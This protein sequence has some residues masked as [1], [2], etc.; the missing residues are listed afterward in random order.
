MRLPLRLQ[1]GAYRRLSSVSAK[2]HSSGELS[3]LLASITQDSLPALHTLVLVAQQGA[4]CRAAFGALRHAGLQRLVLH[5]VEAEGGFEGL[6]QL[7][8]G[9]QHKMQL[10][11]LV[12][13]ACWWA[14]S[15]HICCIALCMVLCRDGRWRR[16]SSWPAHVARVSYRACSTNSSIPCPSVTEEGRAVATSAALPLVCQPMKQLPPCNP[17]LRR[18]GVTEPVL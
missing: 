15:G 5:G 16:R 9:W 11:S 12:Q 14:A 17:T 13:G 7:E 3:A 1:V 8:G 18:A 4:G 2:V 6:E 10:L